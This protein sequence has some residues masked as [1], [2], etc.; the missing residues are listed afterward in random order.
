MLPVMATLDVV[1]LT[2]DCYQRPDVENAFVRQLL[3][4][5]SLVQRELERVGL[6]AERVSWSSPAFDWGSTRAALFRS[7]WDYPARYAEFQ[8]WLDRVEPQV[9]LINAA[10]L[11]R[12]NAD[13]SYLLEL[14]A[15]GIPIVP[16]R[17]LP[18]GTPASLPSLLAELARIGWREA[19]VKPAVSGTARE[20][21]R[22][23]A[24]RAVELDA[25]FQALLARE[26]LLLQPFQEE[27]LE[28]GELSLVVIA[29]RVTHAAR[30]LA[31]PGDFRVQ[32]DHGGTAAPHAPSPAEIRFAEAVVAA[33]PSPPSYARVDFI[34]TAHG[35]RLMELELIEPELFFRFE[36]AAATALAREIANGLR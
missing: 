34:E 2:D 24:A 23:T 28:R 6:R 9:R 31:R 30:K 20:P 12:W 18:A 10:P 13:K 7:T 25:R 11:V 22:V 14:E 15:R 17:Y 21:C 26:A 29:G 16:T 4:E 3:H 5:E 8:A 36:P 32:D 27:I 35:P 19:I 1:L 33:T